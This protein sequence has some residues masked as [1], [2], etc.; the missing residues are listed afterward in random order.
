MEQGA[1]DV[2]IVDDVEGAAE[3]YAQLVEASTGLNVS[4]TDDPEVALQTVRSN[5]IKV[6]VIDQRM[7]TIGTDLYTHIHKVDPSVRAIMLTGLASEAEIGDALNLGFKSYLA[8]ADV[9]KLADRVLREYAAYQQEVIAAQLEVQRP[10]VLTR[11]NRRGLFVGRRKGNEVEYRLLRVEPLDTVV[12]SEWTVVATLQAG[13]SEKVSF[14]REFERTLVIINETADK[15]STQMGF[16]AGNIASLKTSLTSEI[17]TRYK[18][19]ETIRSKYEHEV[20]RT[21]ALRPEPNNPNDLHVL[22]RR[23]E[24]APVYRMV[25][26]ELLVDCNCCGLKN[27]LALEVRISTGRLALRQTDHLSDGNRRTY[28]LGF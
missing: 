15:L 5:S 1:V 8:K 21:L 20:E 24:G 16:S 7:P 19:V 18:Q 13:Q 10:I 6:L 4:H 22:L 9:G 25:R 11:S 14:K 2:L 12:S 26:V 17:T 3:T 27:T 28:E 23:I